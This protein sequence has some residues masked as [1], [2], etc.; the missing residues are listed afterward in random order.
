MRKRSATAIPADFNFVKAYFELKRLRADIECIE[1]S[2]RLPSS[3]VSAVGRNRPKGDD[4][5]QRISR[6]QQAVP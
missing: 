4:D 6:A 1:R 5:V 3:Q 2:S